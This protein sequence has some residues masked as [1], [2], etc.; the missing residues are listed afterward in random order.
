[1]KRLKDVKGL[2]KVSDE[3]NQ[4]FAA[5]HLFVGE[6]K[7]QCLEFNEIWLLLPIYGNDEMSRTMPKMDRPQC[8]QT[9]KFVTI[10][11]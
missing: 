11:V 8:I 6:W 10:S 4:N 3:D 5:I 7:A 1:M 2:R 9:Y